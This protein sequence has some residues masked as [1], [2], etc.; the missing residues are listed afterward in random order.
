MKEAEYKKFVKKVGKRIKELR[1]EN[2]LTQLD[3][4][5]KANIEERQIQRLERGET[6]PTLRTV[7]KVIDGFDMSFAEFFDFTSN[8]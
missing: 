3:L 6:S 8:K 7:Y 1:K 2:D 5:I 4:A